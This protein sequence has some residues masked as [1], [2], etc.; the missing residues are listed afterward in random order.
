MDDVN[1]VSGTNG[2]SAS[3]T[4][5]A[6]DV[7]HAAKSKTSL[8]AKRAQTIKCL[9]AYSTNADVTQARSPHSDAVAAA[10]PPR[11]SDGALRKKA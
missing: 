7:A 8:G 4:M 11:A 3:R 6:S 2:A 9:R 5:R 10:A 1:A